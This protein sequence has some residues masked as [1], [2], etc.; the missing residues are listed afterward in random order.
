MYG[1]M[2]GRIKNVTELGRVPN[3][4]QEKH[5]GYSYWKSSFSK[6]EHD[7]IFQVIIYPTRYKFS[8]IYSRILLNNK[9]YIL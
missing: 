9:I 6:K 2:E 5:E 8:Y 1:E 4:E 3:E 7:G